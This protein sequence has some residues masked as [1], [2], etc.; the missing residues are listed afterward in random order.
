MRTLIFIA[1]LFSL[2]T[3]ANKVPR[4]KIKIFNQTLHKEDKIVKVDYF[5]KIPSV[6]FDFFDP[7]QQHKKVK[8]TAFSL[9][10]L[11]VYFAPAATSV[12]LKAINL[13]KV[14][15][16]RNV[17]RSKTTYIMY[18]QDGQWL[19]NSELGPMR[20]IRKDLGII[21]KDKITEEGADWIWMI[22]EIE[23]VYE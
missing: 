17:E 19:K 21:A 14:H 11:F 18:K 2:S 5:T 9:E 22:N 15:I 23:F 3:F 6:E 20:I 12:R 7:Y 16:Q 10:S 4:Q 13:Y 8:V 1:T